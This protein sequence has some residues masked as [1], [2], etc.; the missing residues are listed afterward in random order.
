VAQSVKAAPINS[1]TTVSDD[2]APKAGSLYQGSVAGE[3][4]E[5]KLRRIHIESR[6]DYMAIGGGGLYLGAY[7]QHK[8]YLPGRLASAGL[9]FISYDEF[10]GN[11]AKQDLLADWYANSRYGGWGNVPTSGGW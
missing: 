8:T 11:P 1:G 9:E 7:Q 3:Q 10:L 6:G 4:H 2:T 5:N